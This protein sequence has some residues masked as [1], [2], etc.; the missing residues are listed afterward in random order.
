MRNGRRV[1]FAGDIMSDG[2]WASLH[3]AD[4][5]GTF[6]SAESGNRGD[7]VMA[8]LAYIPE[9][10]EEEARVVANDR[11]HRFVPTDEL[12]DLSKVDLLAGPRANPLPTGMTTQQAVE[13]ILRVSPRY[14]IKLYEMAGE[15]GRLDV[16]NLLPHVVRKL[17]DKG[18]YTPHIF[19]QTNFFWAFSCYRTLKGFAADERAVIGPEGG[20]A[21]RILEILQTGGAVTA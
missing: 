15:K 13:K 10:A 19:Q 4:L 2:Q 5:G 16:L 17:V 9:I 18:V 8:S 7:A 14:L 12:E 11:L 1:A 20:I 21:C 6:V 3:L